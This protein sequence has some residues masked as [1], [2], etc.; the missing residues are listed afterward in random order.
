MSLS[1]NT[2]VKTIMCFLACLITCCL[3]LPSLLTS[4]L[5]LKSTSEGKHLQHN[6][7][8][9]TS[10]HRDELRRSDTLCK[11]YGGVITVSP[12]SLGCQDASLSVESYR[13]EPHESVSSSTEMQSSHKRVQQHQGRSAVRLKVNMKVQTLL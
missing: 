4:S 11:I 1:G 12:D 8:R 2:V 7:L 9:D 3:F 5:S 13:E 6:G 10:N